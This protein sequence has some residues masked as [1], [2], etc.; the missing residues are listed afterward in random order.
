MWRSKNSTLCSNSPQ[1]EIK[2]VEQLELVVFITTLWCQL[3]EKNKETHF[4]HQMLQK[5]AITSQKTNPII[6]FDNKNNK[7]NNPNNRQV[8][9]QNESSGSI[10]CKG[11]ESGEPVSRQGWNKVWILSLWDQSYISIV[12]SVY[13][14]A[15]LKDSTFSS[16][17]KGPSFAT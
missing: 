16:S 8:T 3:P 5:Q 13:D 14:T 1:Q 10:S 11:S 4:G 7:N 9:V 12:A 15:S 2:I 17:F 6:V